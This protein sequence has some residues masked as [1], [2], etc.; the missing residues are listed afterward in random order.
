M[1]ARLLRQ[2]GTRLSG[3]A[4]GAGTSDGEDARLASARAALDAGHPAQAVDAL[5]ELAARHDAPLEALHVLGQALA[6]SGRLPEARNTLSRAAARQPSAPLLT[7]LGNVLQIGG[8]V[9]SAEQHYRRALALDRTHVPAWHNLALLL[10]ARGDAAEAATCFDE[11]LACEPLFAAAL[12][13]YASLAARNPELWERAAHRIEIAL[14]ADPEASAANEALGFMLLK[15]DLDA[16]RAAAHFERALRTGGA[17]AD[18]FG[19]YAIALQ[20]LGRIA[21]A[22]DAYDRALALDPQNRIVRWHR[23]LALLLAGRFGEAWP[24]YEHRLASEE[25]VR[26]EFP[27]PRWDGRPVTGG[28][29]LVAAEQG[30]GDE[31]MFASCLPDL[32]A[33]GVRCMVE[34]HPKLEALFRRSF[35]GVP[36]YAGS[37][38][39]SLEWLRDYPEVRCY[40]PAGSLPLRFRSSPDAFPAHRG[41]LK[42]DPEKVRRWETRLADL[43]PAR[44]VGL[45]WRGGTVKSRRRLRSPDPSR[46]APLLKTPGIAWISLQYDAQPEEIDALSKAWGVTLHHWP[47]AIADYDETAALLSAL[48]LT[49]SVCTAVI[50][51]GGA[52]G[53]PVW[54]MAPKSP[55]WR[56]G[57]A[58]ERMPWY[59]SVRVTRQAEAGA[60]EELVER[61]AREVDAWRSRAC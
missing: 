51:L 34:C 47:E 39:E 41:Y 40:E 44:P 10:T 9:A 16:D 58:F 1:L 31:I 49:V 32:L 21:E 25:W 15:R 48:D 24:D 55:E 52:L 26:R 5:A 12:R 46:L 22:V 42:A 14:R 18:L 36:I 57:A 23:S 50:H 54:V 45:S 56:Y 8:D 19:N 43:G 11:A 17:S 20:D 38:L 30:L 61:T 3:R 37:Q 6:V 59:P 60:W 53:R 28:L 2:V 7:D 29:L 33:S 35:P 4:L 27:V 13:A